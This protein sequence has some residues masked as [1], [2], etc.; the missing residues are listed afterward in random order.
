MDVLEAE[1]SIHDE[2]HLLLD[3]LVRLALLTLQNSSIFSFLLFKLILNASQ[4]LLKLRH[5]ILP[6]FD[7]AF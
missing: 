2:V 3:L 5:A 6:P 7:F 1:Q 4:A